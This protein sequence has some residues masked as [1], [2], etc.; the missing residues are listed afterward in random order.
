MGPLYGIGALWRRDTRELAPLPPP[1]PQEDT[2][3]VTTC[4]AKTVPDAHWSLL[5]HIPKV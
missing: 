5:V 2:E 1:T 4:A 3:R